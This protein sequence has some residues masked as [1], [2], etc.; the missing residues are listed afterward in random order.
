M[1][2]TDC[3]SGTAWLKIIPFMSKNTINMCFPMD[4]DILAFLEG[5]NHSTSTDSTAALF[6]DHNRRAMSH[7]LWLSNSE[8]RLLPSQ[9]V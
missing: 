3:P 5:A 1:E 9:T 2:L 4:L 6:R 8:K 7:Q